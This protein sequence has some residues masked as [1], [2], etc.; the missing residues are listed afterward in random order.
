MKLAKSNNF[1]SH[2]QLLPPSPEA[3]ESSSNCTLN[4]TMWGAFWKMLGDGEGQGR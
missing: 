4:A 2:P 3:L 1:S